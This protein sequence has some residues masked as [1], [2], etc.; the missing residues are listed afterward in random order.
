MCV[1]NV[2]RGQRTFFLVLEPGPL[3]CALLTS[4]LKP[5]SLN[6]DKIANKTMRSSTLKIRQRDSKQAV[7]TFHVFV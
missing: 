6:Q 3:K 7:Y 4:D 2:R 5:A 1:C